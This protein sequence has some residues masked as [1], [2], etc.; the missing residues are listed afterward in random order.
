[1]KNSKSSLP[2]QLKCTSIFSKCIISA[3]T[4]YRVNLNKTT[5]G[6]VIT[7]AARGKLS[8]MEALRVILTVLTNYN[9]IK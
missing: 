1:M 7:K 8:E 3:I 4:R 5:V 6:N 9:L 2:R